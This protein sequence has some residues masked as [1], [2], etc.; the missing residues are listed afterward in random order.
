MESTII[1]YVLLLLSY[2]L[3][4]IIYVEVCLYYFKSDKQSYL[5]V[6]ILLFATLFVI[7]NMKF[8]FQMPRPFWITDI[9][10]LQLDVLKDYGFPSGHSALTPMLMVIAY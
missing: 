1:T 5:K 7:L 2:S 6:V 3:F 4:L 10:M 9:K 8:H